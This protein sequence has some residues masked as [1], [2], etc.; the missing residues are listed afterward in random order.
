[1]DLNTLKGRLIVSCQALPDE[2]LHSSYIMSRMAKAAESAGAAGIRANSMIDILAIREVVSLPM[3]GII[4][5]EYSGSPVY[6]T[7]TSLEIDQLASCG[8][9]IIAMDAT[10]HS[11][12][13]MPL[14]ELI[15]YARAKYPQILL[16]A[17]TA[18]VT[19]ALQAQQLGF[20]I[21]GT[22]MHGYTAETQGQNIADND[23]AYLKQL[24]PAVTKPAIT[25]G[26]ID[27]PEKAR[28]ALD[29]GAFAVVVGGAIT[30]PQQITKRF[31]AAID[32]PEEQEA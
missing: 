1:M 32:Q 16:M 12:P 9:E 24:I 6:I 28:R 3:I 7:P 18:T 11:R 26:K 27:T 10:N 8:V 22:T 25:E 14:A 21:I 17:D 5:R 4:K 2:P 20:D 13:E 19:E 23:F 15:A 31:V 29:L 30:R